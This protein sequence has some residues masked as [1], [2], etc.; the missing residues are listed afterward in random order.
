LSQA[1]QKRDLPRSILYD[2]GSAMIAAETE[3]GLSR[4]GIL[5]ENTLPFSPFQKE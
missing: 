1:F 2:N 3:Q 4:L 5:F